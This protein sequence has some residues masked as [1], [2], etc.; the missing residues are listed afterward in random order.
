MTWYRE[1]ADGV[2]FPVR[3]VP[4]ASRTEVVG[5][6]DGALKIRVAAPPVEGAANQ[7]LVKFLA[8][9]FGVSRTAVTLISGANA[10]N[11][12]IRIANPGTA[13][14]QELTKLS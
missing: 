5:L 3:V 7:E 12:L 2:T 4:R 14:R 10:R 1:D 11:K 8:R 13:A 9:K 6:Y